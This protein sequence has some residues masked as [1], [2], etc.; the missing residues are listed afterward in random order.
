[1]KNLGL[2]VTVVNNAMLA[3]PNYQ[4]NLYVN[5][6]TANRLDRVCR[7]CGFRNLTALRDELQ[8]RTTPRVAYTFIP[9]F[10]VE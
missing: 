8:R 2:A 1:M 9:P 3:D 4:T 5:L 10:I 6:A 7:N